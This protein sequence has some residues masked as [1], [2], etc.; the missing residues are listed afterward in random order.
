MKFLTITMLLLCSNMLLAHPGHIVS[1]QSFHPFW[2][3]L[4][5]MD[6]VILLVIL[7]LG[8][9]VKYIKDH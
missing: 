7:V 5:G 8:L 3:A 4:N 9:F 6:Y 2:H 1:E